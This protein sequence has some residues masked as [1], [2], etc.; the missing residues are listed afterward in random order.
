DY[1][2]ITKEDLLSGLGGTDE[3]IFRVKRQEF[4]ATEGQTVFTIDGQYLPNNNRISVYV[5][6]N[7]QPN[8]AYEET[9]SNTITLIDGLPAGTKVIIEWFE[10]VNVMDYIHAESHAT[11]GTDPITPEMIGAVPAVEGKGLST[12]DY[13]TAEKM[14]LAGIEEGANK[15]VHPNTHPA[16]M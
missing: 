15:Y 11:D 16:S 3:Y 14:K 12:E 9:N 6:G 7:R 4:T 2:S 8:T 5:W 13:T 1:R 10:V